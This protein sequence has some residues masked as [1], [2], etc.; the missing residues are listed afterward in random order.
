[1]D[2]HGV[3]LGRYAHFTRHIRM[4][5]DILELQISNKKN[6]LGKTV[7]KILSQISRKWPHLS[8]K[9]LWKKSV[10]FF[11]VVLWTNIAIFQKRTF[12]SKLFHGQ[13]T[14][15]FHKSETRF[16]KQFS[17]RHFFCFLFE[18]QECLETRVNCI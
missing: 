5:Q 9:W 17:L 2:F 12:F 13:M 6:A 16:S 15:P 3:N 18:A 7:L 14:A 1:M 11:K 8:I 4:F 10:F